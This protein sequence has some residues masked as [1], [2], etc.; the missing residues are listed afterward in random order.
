VSIATTISTKLMSW[1][2]F[3][4][5]LPEE[6]EDGDELS[7]LASSEFE[8]EAGA[9]F[10]VQRATQHSQHCRKHFMMLLTQ[11]SASLATQSTYKDT[12]KQ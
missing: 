10:P 7:L 4:R 9:G 5:E 6:G 11:Q 12:L 3:C 8:E 1:P 2:T